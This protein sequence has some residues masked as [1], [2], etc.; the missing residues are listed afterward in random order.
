MPGD[1][2]RCGSCGKGM[3]IAYPEGVV[4]RLTARGK[5]FERTVERRARQ[6]HRAVGVES[7]Q[8]LAGARIQRNDFVTGVEAQ[9]QRRTKHH[10]LVDAIVEH[11]ILVD[12]ILPRHRQRRIIAYP[13][14][15]EV[16]RQLLRP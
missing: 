15:V 9:K 11:A 4:E 16:L 12:R 1:K 6:T 7:P 3:A 10:R 14:Q 2:I 13:L 8:L 5:V